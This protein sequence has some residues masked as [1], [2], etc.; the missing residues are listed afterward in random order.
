MWPCVS[1]TIWVS[2]GR[3]TK[4][5]FPE[6]SHVLCISEF[7]CLCYLRVRDTSSFAKSGL[8]AYDGFGH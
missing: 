4:H 8:I 7:Q 5:A 1:F 6:V 3:W 2:V